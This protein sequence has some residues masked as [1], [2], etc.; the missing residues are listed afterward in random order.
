MPPSPA[1]EDGETQSAHGGPQA[2]SPPPAL[3]L[4]TRCPRC[5]TVYRISL[6]QLRAGRGGATCQEC[7]AGFNALETLAETP[8]RAREGPAPASLVSLGRLD[9]AGGNPA[10]KGLPIVLGLDEP[11]APAPT[12]F[13]ERA[14]WAFGVFTL[15]AL[16]GIQLAIYHG[17]RLAQDENLRSWL[18]TACQTLGC[19]LPAFRAPRLIQIIGHDLRPAQDGSG[20]YEFT[21]ALAN[22]ASLP[23][24]FPAVK[25]T[26]AAHNGSPAAVRVFQ[27]EEYRPGTGPALMPVGEPQEIHLLLAKPQR[28]I[29]GF[30]FELL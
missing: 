16:L 20:G 24:A 25:L 18:E 5:Q 29:G 30:A 2:A 4:Y 27:P 6:A 17:P 9:A 21:L 8:A 13:L 1:A 23:Q 3:R 7:Q 19:R 15:L 28:D 10:E 14:A 11:Q 26:L 22:Q 12:S